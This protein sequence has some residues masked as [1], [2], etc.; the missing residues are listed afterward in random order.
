M[1]HFCTPRWSSILVGMLLLVIGPGLASAA[2]LSFIEP[3]A[4][5]G[6]TVV[7]FDGFLC[8]PQATLP[9]PGTENAHFEGCW[10]GNAGVPGPA[11]A[12]AAAA[13][14]TADAYLIEVAGDTN[15]GAIS[16]SIHISI[17]IDAVDGYTHIVAD[18]VSLPDD[19]PIVYPPTGVVG[20]EEANALLLMND[21]FYSVDPESGHVTKVALPANLEIFARS[22]IGGGVP[23]R[24]T[25]WGSLKTI[26]R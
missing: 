10:V 26:Y 16:D 17:Y 25:T 12:G 3:L 9:G 13:N 18:F 5:E 6:T 24:S 11:K 15:P 14:G 19:A 2:S 4:A 23:A 22:D 8:N 7:Q 1:K 21:Y 20:L